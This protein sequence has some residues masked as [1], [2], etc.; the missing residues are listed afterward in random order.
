MTMGET[1]RSAQTLR[2]ADGRRLQQRPMQFGHLADK[3]D[4]AQADR[5]FGARLNS[6]GLP[7]PGYAI[8]V[9]VGRDPGA[10]ATCE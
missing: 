9:L 8:D 3:S 10:L 1:S 2:I 4:A 7:T 6:K 5:S